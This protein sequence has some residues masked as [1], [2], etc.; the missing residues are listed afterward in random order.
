MAIVLVPVRIASVTTVPI[1]TSVAAE[2]VPDS[3]MPPADAPSATVVAPFREPAMPMVPALRDTVGATTE[4]ATER[5]PACVIA[6]VPLLQT[7]P[8]PGSRM[9]P[10]ALP[11]VLMTRLVPIAKS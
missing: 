2:I 5:L 9:S 6:R 10:A 8:L 11:G 1:L 3:V 4:P 7:M